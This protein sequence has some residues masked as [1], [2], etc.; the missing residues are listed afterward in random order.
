MT[1]DTLVL[2]CEH[3]GNRVPAR[4]RTVF[5]SR[6]AQA[7]LASHRGYDPG[8]LWLARRLERALKAPLYATD[9]SRLLVETNLSVGHRRLFSEFSARL[10]QA[11]LD[12]VLATYYEPHRARIEAAIRRELDAG[13]AV[14][15]LAVHSFTPRL[16]G[17]TRTADV[18]LLYDPARASERAFCGDWQRLLRAM[19]PALRVRR[20]YPYRGRDDGLTRHLRR[21][22]RA[23]PYLGIEVEVNQRLLT[24]V[25]AARDRVAKVLTVSLAAMLNGAHEVTRLDGTG[26]EPTSGAVDP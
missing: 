21:V 20:N 15:H 8:T 16:A 4:Y 24:G 12:R 1:P 25:P 9:V 19:A 18:G 14:L 26:R 6:R 2:S 5:A 13:K 11:D 10:P 7:A 23:Q 17:K 22:F 3:G